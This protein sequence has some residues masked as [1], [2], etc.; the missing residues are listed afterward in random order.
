MC[1]YKIKF[2]FPALRRPSKKPT[3]QH[4][5]QYLSDYAHSHEPNFGDG[6]SVLTLLY[7]AYSDNKRLDDDQIK[8]D[9]NA[10]YQAMNGM[11]L[12]EIDKIIYPVCTL[13]RGHERTGFIA[14]INVG[15]R[16]QL[17]LEKEENTFCPVQ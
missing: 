6:D 7:E 8:A 13:C 2:I 11:N 1:C 9:F 5:F 4:Y 12:K 15:M 3:P 16:L 14:G 10:L 17:E